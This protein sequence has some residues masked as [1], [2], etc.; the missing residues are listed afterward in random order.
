MEE[1]QNKAVRKIRK[2]KR[3]RQTVEQPITYGIPRKVNME[4][5]VQDILQPNDNLYENNGDAEN[6]KFI[7]EEDLYKAQ[8]SETI[9]SYL[10]NKTILLLLIL[11]SLIGAVI[12]ALFFSGTNTPKGRGLD[13]VIFNQDVPPG[14]SRCGLVTPNQGCVLYLMNYKTQEISG[15][16]FFTTAAQWT[17]RPRYLI[18]TSNL[19]YTNV[20]IKPGYIAQINI[21][22]NN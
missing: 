15:R 21:P 20:R 11:A 8:S 22:P 18:E 19:H 4:S 9:S 7:T 13:G 12:G 10:K 3:I 17:N 1:T 2:I 5:D 6:I 16:D 14:R